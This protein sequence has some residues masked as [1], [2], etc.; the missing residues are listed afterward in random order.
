MVMCGLEGRQQV[1]TETL[2]STWEYILLHNPE[3]QHVIFAMK[4]IKIRL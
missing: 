3:E 2:V 4:D 1:D